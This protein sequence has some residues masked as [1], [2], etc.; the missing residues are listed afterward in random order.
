MTKEQEQLMFDESTGQMVD[1]K[2]NMKEAPVST[3]RVKAMERSEKSGTVMM[4]MRLPVD[5]KAQLVELAKEKGVSQT[6]VVVSAVEDSVGLARAMSA[7]SDCL[8]QNPPPF[9]PD[10]WKPSSSECMTFILRAVDEA[11]KREEKR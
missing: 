7:V 6:D 2:K 8:Q 10:G 1:K 9:V 11:I 4:S 3:A 5:V